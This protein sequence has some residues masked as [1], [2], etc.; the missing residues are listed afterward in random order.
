MD[1][2]QAPSAQYWGTCNPNREAASPSSSISLRQTW[3]WSSLTSLC[4]KCLQVEE[5]AAHVLKA[6]LTRWAS[7]SLPSCLQGSP[8]GLLSLSPDPAGE[9]PGGTRD[10]RLALEQGVGGGPIFPPLP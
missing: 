1:K 8:S 3:G 2:G 4:T 7:G 9:L 10:P 5:A 6:G